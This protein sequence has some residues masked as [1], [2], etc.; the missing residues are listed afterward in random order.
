MARTDAVLSSGAL[1]GFEEL[2]LFDFGSRSYRLVT[3]GPRE[4][5][6]AFREEP[7]I[8]GTST[9]LS[10]VVTEDVFYGT[11]EYLFE[12]DDGHLSGLQVAPSGEPFSRSVH[13]GG[14]N[15]SRAVS[16]DGSRVIL[17]TGEFYE[18]DRQVYIRE[19]TERP[20]SPVNAKGECEVPT[21]AC[22]IEASASQKTNGSGPGGSDPNG[23]Q[24]A[25]YAGASVDGS[26]VFFT[27]SAELTDD[28]NT[29][30]AD[31]AANLYE[32]DLEDGRLTD[33][34]VDNNAGDPNGGMVLG[35][36]ALSEDGSYVYFTAEGDLAEGAISGQP[37]LSLRHDGTTTF[38]ATFNEG[39]ISAARATPDGT[40]L[41]FLSSSSLTGYDNE[42]AE[43]G[44]CEGKGAARCTYMTRTPAAW[45]VRRAIRAVRDRSAP[46]VSVMRTRCTLLVTSPKMA[47][48]CSS[49]AMMRWP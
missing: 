26:R 11:S 27:S 19:N 28:A 5:P 32:Y 4:E 13:V 25:Q 3:D 24:S 15:L 9:D 1:P 12:W 2:Y 29:G 8:D 21:D 35:V 45:Y 37:N 22:T 46:P 7:K 39:G 16:E 18:S 49:I 36:V 10:H 31:N 43:P 47:A 40:H 34:T 33:L 48:A 38:I 14:G 17:V 30:P 41:A 6:Y 20:Q 42:P 44:E 23:P